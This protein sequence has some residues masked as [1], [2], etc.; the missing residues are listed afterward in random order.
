MDLCTYLHSTGSDYLYKGMIRL[1][2]KWK[3]GL[4]VFPNYNKNA[5]WNLNNFY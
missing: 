3:I 1:D 4:R 5:T 2:Q